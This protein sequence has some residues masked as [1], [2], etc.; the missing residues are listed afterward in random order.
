MSISNAV[1]NLH[2]YK[3]MLISTEKQYKIDTKN[4][5]M[6]IFNDQTNHENKDKIT[7]LISLLI[8]FMHQQS[9]FSFFTTENNIQNTIA[10]INKLCNELNLNPE[11]VFALT[12]HRKIG[13]GIPDTLAIL[14]QQVGSKFYYEH[15]YTGYA[16]MREGEN[17][18]LRISPEEHRWLTGFSL[19]EYNVVQTISNKST[20]RYKRDNKIVIIDST[21]S[22]VKVTTSGTNVKITNSGN[23]TK[24]T[25]NGDSARL[26]NREMN[27]EFTISGKNSI[28]EIH[29]AA[30]ITVRN[31]ADNTMINIYG[32]HRNVIYI[33]NPDTT[34]TIPKDVFHS[35]KTKI[36]YARSFGRPKIINKDTIHFYDVAITIIYNG[37]TITYNAKNDT[38]TDQITGELV[39]E[40]ATFSNNAPNLESAHINEY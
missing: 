20:K 27:A 26:I 9:F 2:N 29:D 3:N 18:A 33:D 36:N 21:A 32:G 6:A 25:S 12:K 22:D 24:I 11:D 38:F 16:D 8:R 4:Q 31:S 7:D 1:T 37:Q 10:E 30:T 35:T 13:I 5:I 19:H 28:M 15:S 17:Q 39:T 40:W 23:L 14:I 34:I